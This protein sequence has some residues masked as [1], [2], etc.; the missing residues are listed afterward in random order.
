MRD[1]RRATLSFASDPA[2]VERSQQ[3]LEVVT[4]DVTDPQSLRSALAGCSGVI[5][6]ATSSGWT[7]LKA[8][9]RTAHT[10]N[11][12][13]VDCLVIRVGGFCCLW[14]LGTNYH[15]GGLGV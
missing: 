12:K 5:F 6:A 10:T 2:L 8:P 11:P 15:G 4:G 9:W 1:P 14:V 7:Q 3:L 13:D